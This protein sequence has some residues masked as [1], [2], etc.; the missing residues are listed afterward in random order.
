MPHEPATPEALALLFTEARTHRAWDGR[1]VPDDL[2]RRIYEL[3]RLPPT[4]GN[5]SPGRFVFVKSK[6]AKEKLR[7]ALDEGNVEKTM[8]APVTAI[9]AYDVE[10]YEQ[11]EK[12]APGR[13][14]RTS[15]ASMPAEERERSAF[16][17]GALE[18]AYLIL[19]SRALGLDCGPM[20]GF[21]KEKV[22]AAFFPDGRWKSSFLVNIG[23]GDASKLRPRAPRLTFADACRLE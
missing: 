2:L 1:P 18:G 21:D 9:V 11:M 16:M 3:A 20:G 17:N 14:M 15:L 23:Y 22:D 10:F 7:P 13:D 4:G 12:L 5:T 6:E 8:T 19:A